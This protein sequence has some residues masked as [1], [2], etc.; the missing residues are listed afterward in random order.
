LRHCA[1]PGG[2]GARIDVLPDHPHL[3]SDAI[4]ARALDFLREVEPGS[5]AS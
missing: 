1:G 4:K 2:A 3:F 5:T